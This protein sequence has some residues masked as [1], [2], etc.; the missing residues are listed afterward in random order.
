MLKARCRAWVEKRG[1]PVFGDGRAELLERIGESGSIRAAAE[2]MKM[3]YRHAWSHLARM[4]KA[5]GKKLVVRHAGGP[6][7]GGSTLTPAGRKLLADYRRF[8]A[9]L[10]ACLV[11]LQRLL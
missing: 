4:E 10:D 11:R 5:L 2:Q 6:A 8:R 7:G 3:S 9:K 1:R